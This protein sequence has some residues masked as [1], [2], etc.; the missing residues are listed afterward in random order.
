MEEAAHLVLDEESQRHEEIAATSSENDAAVEQ[1]TSNIENIQ[2]SSSVTTGDSNAGKTDLSTKTA[3]ETGVCTLLGH[4]QTQTKEEM[5]L[6]AIKLSSSI[7]PAPSD[8]NKPLIEE[9]DRQQQQQQQL[10][11]N[12]SSNSSS[13]DSSS[14]SGSSSSEEDNAS[15]ETKENS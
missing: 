5:D 3:T 8:T 6:A 2:L 15:T 13:N 4:H 14:E 11:E 9:L 7:P 1:L 12:S 10:T